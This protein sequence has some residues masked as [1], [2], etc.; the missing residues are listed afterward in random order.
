MPGLTLRPATDRD[1]ERAG[2]VNFV[3]FYHAALTHGLRPA[4]TSPADSRRYLRHLFAVDPL[5]GM[6]AEE[7]GEVVAV[8]WVH[9][10]GPVA[11]IGPLAV[12]PR[13]QGRGIGRQL[14]ERCIEAV[15]S[16]VPQVRLV[17][18]S[19]NTASLGLYLRTGFRIVAPLLELE[20]PAG[21]ALVPPDPGGAVTVR[22]ARSDDRPRVV[23]RDARAFGAERPQSV[24][25]YLERGRVL[26]AERGTTLVGYALGIAFQG[27]AYLGSA[28]ADDA[29][30]LLH[31]LSTLAVEVGAGEAVL[32]THVPATDRRLVGGLTQLGFRVF[33]AAHYMVR[34]G[35]TPPPANYVLM[36]GD[37]M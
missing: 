15:G 28:S 24:N 6:V 31:L 10:R 32:R 7:D 9:R 27:M 23:A 34:G 8:G 36:N 17:Q 1:V 26:I 13:V 5:G 35:G 11:T 14:L 3:A 33:R 22:A 16:G 12:D 29:D 18:E 19:Y 37:L 20:L 2:D 21:V 25:L 4:V 30:V